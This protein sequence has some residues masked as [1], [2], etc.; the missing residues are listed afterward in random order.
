MEH[1]GKHAPVPL[2]FRMNVYLEKKNKFISLNIKYHVFVSH[3][4]EYSSERTLKSLN[5]DFT[6]FTASQPL[7]S[8]LSN[9][10]RHWY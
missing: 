1:S 7:E 8:G 6:F 2:K 9:K 3:S 5:S 4:I 10:T